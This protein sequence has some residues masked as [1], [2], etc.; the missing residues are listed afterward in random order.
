M[1]DSQV[2]RD[3]QN[4]RV[5]S[6]GSFSLLAGLSTPALRHSDDVG[7][8]SPAYVDPDTGYR[9]YRLDQVS[10]AR[11]Y[12]ILRRLQVP[13]DAMRAVRERGVEVVLAEHRERLR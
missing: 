10:E 6:I 4:G 13:V 3:S 7:L 2:A 12:A 1:L 5:L 11:S 9:R 8:L